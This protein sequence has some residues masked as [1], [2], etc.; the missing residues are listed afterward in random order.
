MIDSFGLGSDLSFV[1]FLS[2]FFSYASNTNF[3]CI[4]KAGHHVQEDCGE[5]LGGII[6]GIL[7]RRSR[8]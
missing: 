6:S 1:A 5:E 4:L 2:T 7:G 8:I 3:F